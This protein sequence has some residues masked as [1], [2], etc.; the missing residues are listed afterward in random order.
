MNEYILNLNQVTKRF[1]NHL[2]LSNFTQSFQHG[3]FALRGPNG[4]GKSTFLKIIAGVESFEKGSIDLNNISLKNNPVQYK[5]NIGYAPDKL[6]IYPFITGLEFI[7]FIKTVKKCSDDSIKDLLQSFNLHQFIHLP[8]EKMSLG[9][10]KKFLIYASCIN[11]PSVL[12]LDEP[13]NELDNESKEC[14]IN[15]INFRKN[16][17]IIIFSSHDEKFVSALNASIIKF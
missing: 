10:Q 7:S 2:I 5:K 1:T 8:L 6:M 14:I 9:T 15:H 13:T 12:I 11:N 4:S 17:C 3:C 16:Q